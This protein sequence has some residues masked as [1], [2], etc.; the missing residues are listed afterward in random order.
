MKN[1]QEVINNKQPLKID[2]ENGV[3]L[4]LIYDNEIEAYRGYWKEEDM[5]IGIWTMETFSMIL[6]GEIQGIKILL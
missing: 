3:I 4:D 6:S 1:L 2:L 5:Y